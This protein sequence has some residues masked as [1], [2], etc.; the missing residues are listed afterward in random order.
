MKVLNV[1]DALSGY[2]VNGVGNLVLAKQLGMTNSAITRAVQ[3]LIEKGWAR[4]DE[5][6]DRFHPTP[7]MGQV[8]G[9]V[10]TDITRA[11]RTLIDVSTTSRTSKTETLNGTYTYRPLVAPQKTILT[12]KNWK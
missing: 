3:V 4:K 12:L 6:T 2:T 1:L 10:L 11:E 7:R 8:F 9:Q 5:T